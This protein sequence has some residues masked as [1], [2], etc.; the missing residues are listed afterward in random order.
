MG[1]RFPSVAS[2]V[3]VNQLPANAT[4]T[5]IC[6]T[7]P[8]NLPID[9]AQVMLYWYI[10]ANIGTG[11]TAYVVRLRRGITTGAPQITAVGGTQ[12][13][14][15]GNGAVLGGSYVDVPGVVAEQQYALTVSQ[16]AATGTGSITD[17]CL[18]AFVL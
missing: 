10:A 17:V 3:V 16:T 11:A 13:V 1:V 8:I 2:T 4:E 15:A 5:V 7:P 6:V 18:I 12:T 14:V 9:S